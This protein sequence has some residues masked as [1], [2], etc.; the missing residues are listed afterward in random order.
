M[1]DTLV[2]IVPLLLFIVLW[3]AL[4]QLRRA[5]LQASTHFG[6]A[7]TLIVLTVFGLWTMVSSNSG[8]FSGLIIYG[9]IIYGIPVGVFAYLLGVSSFTLVRTIRLWRLGES[10][11]GRHKVVLPIVFIVSFLVI[12]IGYFYVEHLESGLIGQQTTEVSLRHLYRNPVVRIFPHLRVRLA[13]HRSI[14]LDILAK[15]FDD[16][17]YQVWWASCKNDKA[18]QEL[19]RKASKSSWSKSKECV[20]A[21]RNAPIEL[22]REWSGDT[23]DRIRGFVARHKNT[24]PDVL[25]L[26]SRDDSQSVQGS[27]AINAAA[28]GE[29]LTR[30]ANSDNPLQ[31]GNVARHVNTP[32]SVLKQLAKDPDPKVRLGLL[33]RVHLPLHIIEIL[34]NDTNEEVQD[35]A[36]YRLREHERQRKVDLLINE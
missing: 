17:N 19:L 22:L 23:D 26:L 10:P 25:L 1:N 18:T 21:N 29:A 27:V 13:G 2:I 36:R 3:I 28:S 4:A 35:R 33:F 14:P 15:L 31:R 20:L 11:P 12:V 5:P 24:P 30:L 8:G 9:W 32:A 16:S 6:L 34:L 7:V